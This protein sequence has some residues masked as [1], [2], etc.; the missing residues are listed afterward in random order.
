MLK[1]WLHS[2]FL[3]LLSALFGQG[4]VHAAESPHNNNPSTKEFDFFA[5]SEQ[6][7]RYKDGKSVAF[8]ETQEDLFIIKESCCNMNWIDT[9]EERIAYWK[10][11]FDQDT[12]EKLDFSS[13][14]LLVVEQVLLDK[15]S[16]DDEWGSNIHFDFVD[17]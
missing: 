11:Q 15:F 10:K 16:D 9:V 4:V 14:S 13:E 6:V 1:K 7:A 3:L 2:I 17:S 5:G 12:A 8:K